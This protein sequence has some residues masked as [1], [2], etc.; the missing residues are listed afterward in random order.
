MGQV[1]S[2]RTQKGHPPHTK[3]NQPGY[4]SAG[5]ETLTGVRFPW[6]KCGENRS[7]GAVTNTTSSSSSSGNEEDEVSVLPEV[8]MTIRL[9]VGEGENNGEDVLSNGGWEEG[10]SWLFWCGE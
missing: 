5:G 4:H 8:E 7:G 2:T 3:K 6:T 1:R 9:P 10:G